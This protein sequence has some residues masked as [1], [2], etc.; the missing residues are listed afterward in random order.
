MIPIKCDPKK[1]DYVVG[2]EETDKDTIVFHFD[3]EC[4]N[5]VTTKANGEEE[6][7]NETAYSGALRWLPQGSQEEMF[8]EGV[9]PVLDDIVVAKLRPGQRIEF[10]AHCR[11][12]VGKDHTKFSP[13]ATASYRL[14]PE[15]ILTEAIRGEKAKELHVSHR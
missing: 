5:E 11:K 15:I 8:P 10:E 4:K 14:L 2:E 13:V 3:V 9:K 12:G 1:L 6:Y 7:V